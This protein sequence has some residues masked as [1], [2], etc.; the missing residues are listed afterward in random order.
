MS[1]KDKAKQQQREETRR[2]AELEAAVAQLEKQLDRARAPRIK[3]PRIPVT[4]N[5]K[6]WVRWCI[7]DTHGAKCSRPAIDAMLYDL[8]AIANVREVIL[9]GD[10][11]DCGGFL[12]EHHTLGYVT[13]A[14]YSFSD[15]IDAAN[16]FLDRLQKAVP[17]A[18]ITY[19]EGNHEQRI[20]KWCV[21][22]ALR[23]QKDAALLR[24]IF[25]PEIVLS[26]QK[27]G[28]EFVKQ[29]D[30][31]GGIRS[32]GTIKRGKCYFTHGAAYRGPNAAR[33]ALHDFK[34][35][36]VIANT[37]RMLTAV[38]SG[39]DDEQIGAWCPGCLSEL[40]PLW[41]NTDYTHWSHGYAFQIVSSDD[42]M[43]WHNNVPI[44]NGVS[45][46][47]KLVV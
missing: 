36:V 45:L 1:L 15:D 10:H 33:K 34:R 16:Q 11:L 2:I 3:Q 25:G 21:T 13:E 47:S 46:L 39:A 9:L 18:R 38:E 12:A 37:H 24:K 42:S 4:R 5:D 19:I 44:I 31:V 41:R 29:G 35:N 23:H 22:S 14:E 6:T 26:L 7:P 32:R 27:R 43:F 40:Q 17:K 20:E 8:E 30:H 28:I